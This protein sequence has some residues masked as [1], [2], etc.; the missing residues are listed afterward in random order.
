MMI[1]MM[2]MMMWMGKAKVRLV[3]VERKRPGQ[4]C[5]QKVRKM[6]KR[7]GRAERAPERKM[8][9]IEEGHEVHRGLVTPNSP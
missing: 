7:Y 4:M 9:A 3:T 6:A 8:I 5:K 2:M 1:M